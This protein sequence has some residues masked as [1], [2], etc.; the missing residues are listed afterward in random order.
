MTKERNV[1]RM[2]PAAAAALAL[3]VGVPGAQAADKTYTP[4]YTAGPSG[5]DSASK[6][7]V[8]PATGK[9]QVLQLSTTPGAIGCA[10]KGGYGYLRVQHVVTAAVTRVAVAFTDASMTPF[11]W[12]KVNVRD[13]KGYVGSLSVRGQKVAEAGTLNVILDRSPAVGKTMTIDFGME[14][15]SACPN[16]DGGM[17]TYPSVTVS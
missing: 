7:T 6:V 3:F 9:V 13:E 15:A 10:A 17:V 1:K 8:D 16:A 2:I 12:L 4:A 11:A 14:V 5:G